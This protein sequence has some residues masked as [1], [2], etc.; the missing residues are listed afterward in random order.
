MPISLLNFKDYCNLRLSETPATRSSGIVTVRR[1]DV[2][3]Q[4]II[5]IP[6][7]TVFSVSTGQSFENPERA[8][9]NES[10]SFIPLFLQ[11]VATGTSQN[12]P[13][14]SDWNTP[15]AGISLSNTNAFTS[16]QA[17]G[18]YNSNLT[19]VVN[20]FS[21]PSDFILQLMLDQS[22]KICMGIIG[23][24]SQTPDTP[25]FQ[26]GVYFLGRYYLET[27]SKTGFQIENG[28]F[29]EVLQERKVVQGIE[30]KKVHEGV[31][32][33]LTGML[34]ADRNPKAFMPEVQSGSS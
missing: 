2:Q 1:T 5:P 7:N 9:L 14:T 3:S 23:N 28:F 8:E 20:S 6:I 21:V 25:T 11:S 27:R 32:R 31:L 19:G 34:T 17:A 4:T 24:P 16:G 29:T 10:Q 33:I 30:D 26:A 13:A 12:I 22:Q 18:D 15:I